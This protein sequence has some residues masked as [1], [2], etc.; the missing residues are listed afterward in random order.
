MRH[1]QEPRIKWFEKDGKIVVGGLG[2]TCR[3][4]ENELGFLLQGRHVTKDIEARLSAQISGFN[5]GSVG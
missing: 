5:D 1:L 2:E 3:T 4:D